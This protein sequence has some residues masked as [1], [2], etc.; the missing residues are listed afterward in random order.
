MAG[1]YRRVRNWTTRTT[2]NSAVMTIVV[3][4]RPRPSPLRKSANV[5]PT[6]VARILMIQKKTVTSGTLLRRTRPRLVPSGVV[7]VMEPR[8]AERSEHGLNGCGGCRTGRGAWL[9]GD[10]PAVLVGE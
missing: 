5:S 1:T 9:V 8:V 2:T 7:F 4:P 6:V 10:N 3:P